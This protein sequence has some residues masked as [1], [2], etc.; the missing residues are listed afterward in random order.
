MATEVFDKDAGQYGLLG[1]VMA[2]GS[3]SGALLAARRGR[4]RLRLVIVSA[5]LFGAMEVVSGLMPTYWLFMASLVPVGLFALTFITAAN[6]AIQLGVDPVLRGRV[7]ALYMVVFF[8]GTPVGAPL[9]GAAAEA[10]GVRWALVAGGLVSAAAAVVAAA[11][12]A[13]RQGRL[14]LAAHPAAGGAAPAAPA[15]SVQ[16]AELPEPVQPPELAEVTPR[17]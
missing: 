7:L 4:P 13:R 10:F 8:G 3:L 5:V 11:V 6:S 15:A 16:P 1:S 12:L 17:G 2:V 9:L 14:R